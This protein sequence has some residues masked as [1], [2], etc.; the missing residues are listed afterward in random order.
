MGCDKISDPKKQKFD[1]FLSE[2]L[3]T[4]FL[5][6]CK[7]KVKNFVILALFAYFTSTTDFGS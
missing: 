1:F 5:Q 3:Q 6:K 4:P 7:A 2:D